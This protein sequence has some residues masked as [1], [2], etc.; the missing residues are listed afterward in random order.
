MENK[1]KY[2]GHKKA[3]VLISYFNKGLT[4]FFVNE[5]TEPEC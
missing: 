5:M 2:F 1:N 3:N 4:K